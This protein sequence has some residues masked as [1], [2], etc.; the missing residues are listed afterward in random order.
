[1]SSGGPGRRRWGLFLFLAVSLSAAALP[2]G[3]AAAR[4]DNSSIREPAVAVIR[5]GS[6]LPLFRGSESEAKSVVVD[7]FLLDRY[8]VTRAEFRRFLLTHADWRRSS[9]KPLFADEGYLASWQSDLGPGGDPEA[10]VT[11]VSWFAAKAFCKAAGKRLPSAAEWEYAARA[12]ESEPDGTGDRR[13]LARIL[14][15]YAKPSTLSDLRPVGAW[16]NYWGVYDLHG[17]VWEWVADFNSEFTT[18]ES[19]GDTDLERNLFCGAGALA[20]SEKD[21]ANYAAFMR[22]AF[23]SSL[24]GTYALKN[25]GFRCA[26]D[27]PSGPAS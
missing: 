21:R 8:P 19:R 12:N 11:E 2:R 24:R 22:Y 26:A 1:M 5:G 7:D 3:G 13:Y 10:P 6:Y 4:G 15:W 14:E 27:A 25:L 23:R 20:A 18:G 16:K 17:L 9:R